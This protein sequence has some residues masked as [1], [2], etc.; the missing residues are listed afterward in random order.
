LT[1]GVG[2]HGG[3]AY[4]VL[5]HRAPAQVV[6]MVERL[7]GPHVSVFVHLD[8]RA[9]DRVFWGVAGPLATAPRV[10]ML[11]RVRCVW[12][13]WG[14]VEAVL[15]GLGAALASGERCEHFVVVSGQDY[16]LASSGAVVEFLDAHAGCS[17]V[18]HWA[19][20]SPLWG[21]DGGRGRVRY[22]HTTVCGHKVRVPFP[23]RYP[24]GLRPF[25]GSLYLTLA[26]RAA[27]HVV[28]YGDRRPDLLRFH[29]HVWIPDELYVPTV[30]MNSEHAVDVIGENLWH[31][32]WPPAPAKHPEV[33][34]VDAMPRLRESATN[35][36]AFGGPARR[37][38]WARKFDAA[39]DGDVLDFIDRELLDAR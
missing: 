22:W 31:I 27:I 29:R 24:S 10:Q 7:V 33:L 28:E 38:L 19:L 18:A 3:V 11:P 30:L 35:G 21:R 5:A 4:I 6:R 1:A 37:K 34:T 36:S 13:G 14:I 32:E 26:R 8:A 9:D 23:R 17:F 25:G 39:V 15:G 20:P 2:G 12:G 16:P